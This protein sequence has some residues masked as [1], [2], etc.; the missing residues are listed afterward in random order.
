[1]AT[2]K[3]SAKRATKSANTKPAANRQHITGADTKKTPGKKSAAKKGG[4]KTSAANACWPGYEP[5]PGK[6]EGEK[7]SCEPK[8][9]QTAAERK[10]DQ[11]AAAAAR[12]SGQRK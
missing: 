3:K 4:K 1:M 2:A 8:K 5:V 7:G 9:N 6:M 12:L 11:K 10:G